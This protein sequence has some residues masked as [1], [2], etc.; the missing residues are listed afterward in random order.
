[1][2]HLSVKWTCMAFYPVNTQV[3]CLKFKGNNRL[4]SHSI[5]WERVIYCVV[6]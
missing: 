1:M 3:P 5:G 6:L 2:Y 4:F